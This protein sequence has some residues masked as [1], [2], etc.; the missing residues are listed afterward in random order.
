MLQGLVILSAP[1]LLMSGASKGSSP[2]IEHLTGSSGRLTHSTAGAAA[3]TLKAKPPL[4]ASLTALGRP[5]AI[6]L[7]KRHG[8]RE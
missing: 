1:C 3:L 5:A 7:L 2:K 8:L 4:R 6:C